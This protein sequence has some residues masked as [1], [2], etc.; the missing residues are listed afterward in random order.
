M[1]AVGWHE[2]GPAGIMPI[3]PDKRPVSAASAQL[4]AGPC[5]GG[6]RALIPELLEAQ[7]LP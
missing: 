3:I 1:T 2:P 7:T 6:Q 5:G 4:P